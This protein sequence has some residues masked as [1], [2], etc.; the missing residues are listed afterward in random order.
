M[1]P[2]FGGLDPGKGD[3]G[4]PDSIPVDIALPS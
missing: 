4:L 2:A 1:I 3:A